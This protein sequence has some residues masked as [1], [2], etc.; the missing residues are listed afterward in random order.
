[1]AFFNIFLKNIQARFET[2]GSKL[3]KVFDPQ[4]EVHNFG[5]RVDKNNYAARG[6]TN[7]ITPGFGSNTLENL[8]KIIEKINY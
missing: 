1:M 6:F 8:N 7:I 5:C 3:L 4:Q 2:F